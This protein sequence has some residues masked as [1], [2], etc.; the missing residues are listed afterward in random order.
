MS[1]TVKSFT[2]FVLRHNHLHD[3]IVLFR[4]LF[5]NLIR[6]HFFR[7]LSTPPGPFQENNHQF[8]LFLDLNQGQLK[9]PCVGFQMSLKELS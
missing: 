4:P 9:T 5:M 2:H 7:V 1:T 6:K 8:D 3:Q